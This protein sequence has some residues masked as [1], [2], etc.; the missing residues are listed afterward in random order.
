MPSV[1]ELIT[2][3]LHVGRRLV[4]LGDQ[5]QGFF[6][7]VVE[8]HDA[9]VG[10]RLCHHVGKELVAR[11]LRLEPDHVHAQQ[12]RLQSVAAPVVRIDDRQSQHI[13]HE[14]SIAQRYRRAQARRRGN[15]APCCPGNYGSDDN[16]LVA[17]SYLR[18]SPWGR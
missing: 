1:D 14:Y 13:A 3:M 15:G 18:H 9:D 4:Q 11:A 7:I 6:G 2:R 16:E 17:P 12:R 8:R 10:M 5:L